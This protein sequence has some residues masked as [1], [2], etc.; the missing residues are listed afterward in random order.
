MKI[1]SE[2][3]YHSFPGASFG[4]LGC[5]AMNGFVLLLLAVTTIVTVPAATQRM[6]Q[7]LKRLRFTRHG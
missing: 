5:F 7:S 2:L 1:G 6:S 4:Q 3:L